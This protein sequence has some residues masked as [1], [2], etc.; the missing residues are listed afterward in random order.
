M[1]TRGQNNDSDRSPHKI[2]RRKS[3]PHNY[4]HVWFV[5]S[6]QA[7][8]HPEMAI[9]ELTDKTDSQLWNCSWNQ[10]FIGGDSITSRSVCHL[11]WCRKYADWNTSSQLQFVTRFDLNPTIQNGMIVY[12]ISLDIDIYVGYLQWFIVGWFGATIFVYSMNNSDPDD[13]ATI[14]ASNYDC[15]GFWW[16]CVA[17]PWQILQ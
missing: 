17:D 11:L 16:I 6:V 12:T 10:V 8:K 3:S 13:Q 14:F 7:D 9:A 4:W 15:L 5:I 1:W 2:H